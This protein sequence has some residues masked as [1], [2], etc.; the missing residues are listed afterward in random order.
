M[1]AL[2]LPV[3]LGPV[4]LS[5]ES[6]AASL[7]DTVG[8]AVLSNPKIGALKNNRRATEE[9]L[10]QGRGLYLPQVDLRAAIGP[11]WADTLSTR[12][13]A[14]ERTGSPLTR[15]ESSVVIQ[16][17]IFDGFEASS[18]VER[19]QHRVESAAMRVRESAE[20]T[21]LDAVQA[22]ID[23]VRYRKLVDLSQSN[24][25][26]HE[27]YLERVR[28]RVK[29]GAGSA[30]EVAQADARLQQALAQL[31][32]NRKG[33]RDAEASYIK[34]VGDAPVDLEEVGVPADALAADL[35]S[36]LKQVGN[37]PTVGI[38]DADVAVAQAEIGGAESRFYP[39]LTLEASGSANADTDG[40][41]AVNRDAQVLLVARWN[42]YRGG[43]DMANRREAVARRAQ[44]H[45]EQV[46]AVR[47]FEEAIR[48]AWAEYETTGEQ[49]GLLD[50]AAYQNG[51]VRD[52][53]RE[54]FELGTRSLL[55]LLDSENELYTTLGRKITAEEAHIFASYKVLAAGGQLLKT[56]GVATPQEATAPTP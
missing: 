50:K 21:G 44:A 33:L 26:V 45:D 37:S 9:E 11:E 32:D 25:A 23:V 49:A 51:L 20:N 40:L 16:Q 10:N 48:K 42:L 52:A 4:V 31:A 18:E 13:A 53:Y 55:D 41:R 27:G 38:K 12:S 14:P 47:E 43:I 22:H 54:Q 29:S 56:V 35:E 2:A 5:G 46:Q 28:E 30:D 36:A 8:Q 24:V 3:V 34:T 17:R 39:K 6:Q 19:Q 15:K 7:Q 1:G